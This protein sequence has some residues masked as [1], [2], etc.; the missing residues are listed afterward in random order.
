MMPVRASLHVARSAVC[1]FTGM[2]VISAGEFCLQRLPRL[3]V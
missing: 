1:F 3:T 2:S